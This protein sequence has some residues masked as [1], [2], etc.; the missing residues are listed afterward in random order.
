MSGTVEHVLE[1]MSGFGAVTTRK[2]FGAVALYHAG[3]IFGMVDDD[4]LYLKGDDVS[5]PDF[6]KENLA[7]F[8]YESKSGGRAAM[9][10]WRAPERCL[11]DVAEM[12]IW[13]RKAYD[14][15]LRA[16]KPEKKPANKSKKT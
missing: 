2:M 13:C 14:A 8:T 4:L 7:Q 11:D 1:Q 3:V 15:A 9:S 16:K 5:K 12:K 6:E 10:Y